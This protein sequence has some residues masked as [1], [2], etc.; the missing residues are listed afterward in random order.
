MIGNETHIYG[1]EEITSLVINQDETITDET[2][3]DET[4]TDNVLFVETPPLD[5]YNCSPPG[6]LIKVIYYLIINYLAQ[7]INAIV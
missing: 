7:D 1:N 5:K 3:T 2:I 4:L 6:T